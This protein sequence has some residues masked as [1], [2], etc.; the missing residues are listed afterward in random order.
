MWRQCGQIKADD[1]A[2]DRMIVREDAPTV[3]LDDTTNDS[4]AQAMASARRGPRARRIAADERLER[5]FG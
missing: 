3:R 2:T 4:Q 1:R 5:L